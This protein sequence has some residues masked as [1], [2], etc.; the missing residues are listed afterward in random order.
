MCTSLKSICREGHV[1]TAGK[2][3]RSAFYK[4]TSLVTPIKVTQK[5]IP[6][7]VFLGC[8][9]IKRIYLP[10]GAVIGSG[11]FENCDAERIIYNNSSASG[12]IGVKAS[13]SNNKK[14]SV[15]ASSGTGG[16]E[17][18][19]IGFKDFLVRT[20][21]YKCRAQGHNIEDVTAIVYCLTK[22]G[23]VIR[24]EIMAG[25]CQN[26][27]QYYL[28]NREYDRLRMNYIL[29]CR[30]IDS[31]EPTINKYNND[32]FTELNKESILK[33]YGYTVNQEDGLSAIQR[34]TILEFLLVSNIL[35]KSE[36]CSHLDWLINTRT[37]NTAKYRLA[38]KKWKEDRYYIEHYQLTDSRDVFVKSIVKGH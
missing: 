33:Q 18:H 20:D 29:L 22:A 2:I 38:L 26:C 15:R 32:A 35:T 3:G 25:Y 27:N 4:C 24:K 19:I 16:S 34:R 37:Y 23:E 10:Q 1:F 8:K 6:S 12:T 31:T 17:E 21:I 7:D 11:A 28:L 13:T 14:E 5:K 36:I 9:G 30:V